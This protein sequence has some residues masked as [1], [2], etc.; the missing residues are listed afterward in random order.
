VRGAVTLSEKSSVLWVCLA[1]AAVAKH[2][3]GWLSSRPVAYW[4]TNSL[5]VAA[6]S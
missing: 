1:T 6:L 2:V 4:L 3:Q 5:L